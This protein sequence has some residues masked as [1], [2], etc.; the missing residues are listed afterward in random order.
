M[1]SQGILETK[2]A[3]VIGSASGIGAAVADGLSKRGA[4]VLLADI[5]G[6]RVRERAKA[7]VAQG[8][9]VAAITCD[10]GDE[11]QVKAAVDELSLAGA[12]WTSFTTMR[13]P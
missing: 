13:R 1:S 6:D 5:D 2:V 12:G 3:I 11:L 9:N 8:R 10:V 7:L 4:S